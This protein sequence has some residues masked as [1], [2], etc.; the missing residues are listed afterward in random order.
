[1]KKLAL[2]G[3]SISHSLSPKLFEAA[4]KPQVA[5][6]YS[7]DQSLIKEFSY[8]LLDYTSLE[9]AMTVFLNEGYFGANITSPYK[10]EI[11]SYCTDLDSTAQQTGAAN[12]IL[13]HGNSIK[14]YNTDCEG[15]YGPIKARDIQPCKVIVVGV[16]GAARAAIFALKEAKFSVTVVNRTPEKAEMLAKEYGIEWE[17][18]ES[19]NELLKTTKLLI[20]TIAQAT[21]SFLNAALKHIIIFEANYKSPYFNNKICKE[22][23]S[24]AEWL[25][26]QAV[27]SFRLFTQ[28]EP[29]IY[30]MFKLTNSY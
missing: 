17:H 15:A 29:N 1:M 6:K 7:T 3:D 20:Y 16:G 30:A 11:L 10:E 27:P 14:A 9:K 12:L 23:I 22:Y 18:I 25:L 19:L 5:S 28:R 13:K 26:Y 8:T 4:Y 24:G 21:P 2:I